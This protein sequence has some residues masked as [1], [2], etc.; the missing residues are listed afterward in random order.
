MD[1]Y[2][3]DWRVLDENGKAIILCFAKTIDGTNIIVKINGYHPSC[4]T[5]SKNGETE[6]VTSN[7]ITESK[8]FNRQYFQTFQSLRDYT[9][10]HYTCMSREEDVCHFLSTYSLNYVGWIS[11]SNITKGNTCS[12]NDISTSDRHIIPSFLTVAF[13]IEVYSKSR[14]MP[15]SYRRDDRIFMISVVS[16]RGDK[17]IIE[18]EDE[19]R[20]ID[21][22]Y[23]CIHDLDPD[24]IT[25]FNIFNFDFQYIYDRLNL[26][27]RSPL[28]L[29]RY[30]SLPTRW[31]SMAWSNASYGSQQFMKPDIP[32]RMIIDVFQYFKRMSL[33]KHS[34]NYISERFLGEGKVDLSIEEM[35][36]GVEKCVTKTIATYCMKDSLLVLR[37]I[38]KFSIIVD[39]FEQARILKCRVDDILTRGEQFKINHNLVF[40]CVRRDIILES[41]R[42]PSWEGSYGGALVHEPIPGLYE[43]CV[44]L[45]YQSLYPSIIISHNICPSTYLCSSPQIPAILCHS[46]DVGH[47]T[48][49]FRKTPTGIL[50]GLLETL[51]RERVE[52]KQAMKTC[53]NDEIRTILDKRQ[54][55][56]KIAANSVYG[57]TG[58]KYSKY[59]RHRYCAESISGGGRYYFQQLVNYVKMNWSDYTLVYGDTDSCILSFPLSMSQDTCVRIGHE[60]CDT[61]NRQLPYPIYLKYESFSNKMLIFSKK[62][63][64]MFNGTDMVYKGVTN[65][66][67]GYCPIV[68]TMYESMIKMIFDDVSPNIIMSYINY[69][70]QKILRG[71]EPIKEF[72]IS[73]SV[74]SLHEYS[75]DVPQKL[76]AQRLMDQEGENIIPGTRLEYVFVKND[77]KKQGMKMYRPEEVVKKKLEI[78]YRYYVEKQLCSTIDQVLSLI[79]YPDFI[80]TCILQE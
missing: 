54:N 14:T 37:L 10:R 9:Q 63:Y 4:Y 12:I 49:Y 7:D 48:H 62:K 55:A 56:L 34:L 22:F 79:G 23:H 30:K 24:I 3:F 53:D 72:L 1:I 28:D 76:M 71:D 42:F 25:G 35:M 46:I 41:T 75:T 32:G 64:I 38:D 51:L 31:E 57:I 65:A 19:M 60:I 68:K 29:S 15:K 59:L 5:Y 40:E 66:R 70:I 67:R 17:I 8:Q 36:S 13:D 44:T 80:K 11:I 78:D 27:L 18:N 21:Q 6:C 43:N 47:C 39:L 58:A 69:R 77:E 74:K 73:K 2:A 45:D 52:V 26:R 50:S 20:C 16:S 33:E 61:Y